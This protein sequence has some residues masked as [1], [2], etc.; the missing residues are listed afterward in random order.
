MKKLPPA[1]VLFHARGFRA[2]LFRRSL[3]W[4]CLST[5]A[6]S[7][8]TAVCIVLS[9][10]RDWQIASFLIAGSLLPALLFWPFD[11]IIFLG[12]LREADVDSI[13]ESW[14]EAEGP[15]RDVLAERLPAVERNLAAA[16][17]GPR[18][19]VSGLAR[20]ALVALICLATLQALSFAMLARPV[21]VWEGPAARADS[22][23]RLAAED[24][25]ARRAATGSAM[26]AS[27]R[28]STADEG[29]TAQDARRAAAI[30]DIESRKMNPRD[31]GAEIPNS[32]AEPLPEEGAPAQTPGAESPKPAS[33]SGRGTTGKPDSG[34]GAPSS[35]PHD[36]AGD[37]GITGFEGS[38]ASG[39]PSPLIDYQTR[40]FKLL[41]SGGGRD[42]RA[43]GDLGTIPFAELQRRWFSSFELETGI[44][45]RDDPWTAL[46]RR[47][48][49]DIL[50]KSGTFR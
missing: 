6:L 30:R 10:P 44:G 9:L 20:P 35:P 40:L 49:A 3:L 4:I 38:G 16:H 48:W 41:S 32:G 7:S 39:L 43:S 45:P 27:P 2:E 28:T 1:V 31:I 33:S 12:P 5:A 15:A 21:L 17:R 36:Q 26:T 29:T 37:K 23:L 50:A 8:W 11:R 18:S 24:E 14:L 34:S 19:R 22:G 13:V 47:R 46:L 42:A 25:A